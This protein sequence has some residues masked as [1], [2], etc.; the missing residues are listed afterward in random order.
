[1][2]FSTQDALPVAPTAAPRYNRPQ[3]NPDWHWRAGH[4][5]S[6]PF[7]EPDAAVAHLVRY[8]AVALVFL[9]PQTARCGVVLPSI[10]LGPAWLVQPRSPE[11]TEAVKAFQRGDFDLAK[12]LLEKARERE[13]RDRRERPLGPI[14]DSLPPPRAYLLPAPDENLVR[15]QS[16]W[17]PFTK[18]SEAVELTG[19]RCSE[20]HGPGGPERKPAGPATERGYLRF[21][22][23]MSELTQR[24]GETGTIH[25]MAWREAGVLVMLRYAAP[26]TD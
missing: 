24:R 10:P 23:Q 26:S 16:L 19:L 4:W 7:D 13:E 20:T 3:V 5:P 14:F 15:P 2:L 18:R 25:V 21:L 11:V 6:W 22:Q 8:T 9:I 1:M 17:Q 12:E